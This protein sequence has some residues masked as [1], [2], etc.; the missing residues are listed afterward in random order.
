MK[1]SR[2]LLFFL[3]GVF[4]CNAQTSVLQLS[5]TAISVRLSNCK[6][7]ITVPLTLINNYGQTLNIEVSD[8]S[9]LRNQNNLLRVLILT[10]GRGGD[11]ES[12]VRKV[13]NANYPN[14]VITASP[15]T[16]PNVARD[17]L[18]DQHLVVALGSNPT[19]VLDKLKNPLKDF[20]NAGGGL[21]QLGWFSNTNL[22]GLDV[23]Y[24]SHSG[25]GNSVTSIT[26]L[27]SL[28]PL[29][30]DVNLPLRG[31]YPAWTSYY[32]ITKAGFNK[33][34]Q[35]PWWPRGA[36][37]GT[38]TYGRG[39]AVLIGFNYNYVITNAP[40]EKVLSNSIVWSRK[41]GRQWMEISPKTDSILSMDSI[42]IELKFRADSLI[43]G[44]YYSTIHIEVD[45]SLQSSYTLPC[46]LEVNGKA[47]FQIQNNPTCIDLDTLERRALHYEDFTFYNSGCDS[48]FIQDAYFLE[49]EFDVHFQ[50]TVLAPFDS[51]SLRVFFSSDTVGVFTDSLFVHF[52]QDSIRYCI[53][54]VSI[55]SSQL[56]VLPEA[57]F[58]SIVNQNDSIVV[59]LVLTNEGDTTLIIDTVL[60]AFQGSVGAS[61]I[62]NYTYSG[63]IPPQ[64]TD[65]LYLKFLS[66]S[67]AFADTH[68][69]SIYIFSND[70]VDSIVEIP[71]SLFVKGLPSLI[72]QNS[73][74]LDFDSLFQ[75]S[76]YEKSST[77]TN[78]AYDTAFIDSIITGPHFRVEEDYPT[79][80]AGKNRRLFFTYHPQSLGLHTDTA[81]IYYNDGLILKRC[82]RG[83]ALPPP[84][85]S[86]S[87]AQQK[88]QFNI[89]ED[90]ASIQLTIKNHGQAELSWELPD[91]EDQNGLY[92]DN[93]ENGFKKSLW[94]TIGLNQMTD[95]CDVLYGK[96]S[97]ALANDQLSTRILNTI[98]ADT[99][100]MSLRNGDMCNPTDTN[101]RLRISYR[102]STIK[103]NLVVL[104]SE[105]IQRTDSNIQLALP[106]PSFAR[107]PEVSF[108]LYKFD[109]WGPA[110]D[111]WVLDNFKVGGSRDSLFN[112]FSSE[113]SDG[114]L[115][116]GDSI[117]ITVHIDPE[118][119]IKGLDTVLL[120][121]YSND[122]LQPIYTVAVPIDLMDVSC[123]AFSYSNDTFCDTA[124]FFT[125]E[126]EGNPTSWIWDF[127]DGDSAFVQHPTHSYDDP[128]IH[129]VSMIAC[130]EDG[131]DTTVNFVNGNYI[132][133][134]KKPTCVPQS[135]STAT[136]YGISQVTLGYIRNSSSWSFYDDFTCFSTTLNKQSN[137]PIEIITLG[138][139]DVWAW[140]D[141]NNDGDFDSTELVVHEIGGRT[142]LDT[143]NIP[144]NAVLNEGIRLRVGSQQSHNTLSSLDGCSLPWNGRG[145]Y[146]DYTVI[147]VSDS[148]AP[149]ARF[150]T[151]VDPFVADSCSETILFEDHSWNTGTSFSYEFVTGDTA[152][153]A[154]PSYTYYYNGTYKVRMVVSNAFGADTIERF[155]TID[156]AQSRDTLWRSGCQSFTSP[157]G[158]LWDSTGIYYDTLLNSIGCDSLIAVYLTVTDIDTS[159][160]QQGYV[161]SSNQGQADYQWLDCNN[162]YSALLNE[163][164]QT[165]TAF[166][167]GD[168]A[169]QISKNNCIDTSACVNV[170][171][172]NIS[173]ENR[174]QSLKIYPNPTNGR[175]IIEN[176]GTLA[177][178]TIVIY[179]SV[180]Q[181]MFEESMTNN[182]H[183]LYIDGAKGFYLIEIITADTRDRFKVLKQ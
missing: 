19:T 108:Q 12:N 4:L 159:V 87:I 149:R 70:A 92:F 84:E 142:H 100:F 72:W 162:N 107:G 32:T 155:I 146:E 111:H 153:I 66:Q 57:V 93:F 24:G 148:L 171:S 183:D 42:R 34:A 127:G 15:T 121:I 130:G 152:N 140:I 78:V 139:E 30:K 102:R 9:T 18:R 160:R 120:N 175:L 91:P 180:G 137:H 50:D 115:A 156:N 35:V 132:P 10:D 23:F 13:I 117:E 109:P 65:T 135:S 27:D 151:N 8:S 43:N 75:Y 170:L 67:L 68:I 49:S 103:R 63:S 172:V 81:I 90:S 144:H 48:L 11:S 14:N 95:S 64:G 83:K 166:S 96:G 114:L 82:M 5:D 56:T 52:N 123:A 26:I 164:N 129:R 134:I 16:D 51:S 29:L 161:L 53:K 46:T 85:I 154:Y 182:R 7:S 58:T 37:L 112:P 44:T 131:C 89:C 113:I 124:L 176:E 169:V 41:A 80:P 45:D 88:I 99:L 174:L 126:S 136:T 167:N 69:T 31:D 3:F 157:S 150:M 116:P 141:F 119:L 54:A 20:M 79:I 17:L 94:E 178:I 147:I 62:K 86:A 6:D 38:N 61:W 33:I 60:N 1:A 122:P 55:P 138:N 179:N 110:D 145:H 133:S 28:S 118:A 98:D 104:N 77:M 47:N 74:C 163:T 25:W 73:N 39:R 22:R 21:I 76:S 165:F 59:P 125:D 101:D 106:L 71:C 168:Y 181:K 105:A 158:K 143:F 97:V 173:N 36:V 40:F 177:P 2:L 128:G